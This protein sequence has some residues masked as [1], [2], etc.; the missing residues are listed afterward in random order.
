MS[1]T[2]GWTAVQAEER[3]AAEGV[4][5]P[6]PAALTSEG[7]EVE[8]LAEG[9]DEVTLLLRSDA[10]GPG[11]RRGAGLVCQAV[12]R[13]RAGHAQRIRTALTASQ[14]SC[15][16]VLDALRARVGGDVDTMTLRRAGSTV[17]VTLD[18]APFDPVQ[19]PDD[20]GPMAVAA[21]TARS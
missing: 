2:L 19:V 13:A 20:L 11:A 10:D 8:M 3:T 6:A 4:V 1:T 17:L 15:G 14:P 16:I 7:A 9:L 18:L 21:A 12:A 5:H